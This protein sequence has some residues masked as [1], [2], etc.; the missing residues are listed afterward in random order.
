MHIALRFR[1]L[2]MRRCLFVIHDTALTVSAG[3]GRSGQ[4]EFM[5]ATDVARRETDSVWEQ[6][7]END[8]DRSRIELFEMVWCEKRGT[9]QNGSQNYQASPRY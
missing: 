9:P 2:T 8:P 7:E 3:A 4:S 5:T 1:R 6:L